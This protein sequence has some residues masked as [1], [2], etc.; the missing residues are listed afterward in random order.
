MIIKLT[1]KNVYS[2]SSSKIFIDSFLFADRLLFHIVL[3]EKDISCLQRGEEFLQKNLLAKRKREKNK[4]LPRKIHNGFSFNRNLVLAYYVIHMFAVT[5]EVQRP[6]AIF[7][8]VA[9]ANKRGAFGAGLIRRTRPW[10]NISIAKSNIDK[11]AKW[12]RVSAARSTV[13]TYAYTHTHNGSM[14][15]LTARTQ[16]AHTQMACIRSKSA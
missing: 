8:V 10:R 11:C 2:N 15:T 5:R 9:C 16:H 1:D 6:R 14:H 3:S 4:Y 12:R 7:G 13:C